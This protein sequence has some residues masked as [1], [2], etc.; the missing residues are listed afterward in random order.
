MNREK[1]SKQVLLVKTGG[2]IKKIKP[3]YKDFEDWFARYAGIPNFLQV[4]VFRQQALPMPET[5]DAVLVTGSDAMVSDREDWSEHTAAW[6]KTAIDKGVPVLGV[7]YG[8]QLLAYALGGQVGPNPRGRQIGTVEARLTSEGNNDP[9]LGSLPE[10]FLA[11]TSHV[12]AVLELPAG[13]K[14]LASSP[15]D[16]NFAIRFA[17]NAWGVQFHPEFSA[18]VMSEYIHH[19]ADVL[20]HE[21][22]NPN[23]LLE[24]VK[25]TP[26]AHSTLT[27]FR[28]ML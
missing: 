10:T 16:G 26:Q 2:T 7:C 28:K 27:S 13:S 21:G 11:Q 3:Q 18:P 9:L 20:R 6:L 1:A 15:R 17:D 22:L 25:D 19:R 24:R 8:H 23:H 14:R 5:V 4:D 12:E